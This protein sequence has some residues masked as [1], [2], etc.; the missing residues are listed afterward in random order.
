MWRG[1]GLWFIVQGGAFGACEVFPFLHMAPFA[2]V[3]FCTWHPITILELFFLRKI[4]PELTAAN[5]PLFAEEEWPWANIRAHLPLLYMWDTYHS[6]ACQ[7]VPCPHLGWNWWNP[8]RQSRTCTLNYCATGQAP[9]WT[10]LVSTGSVVWLSNNVLPW[11][12]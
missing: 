10:F 5:P 8:G 3:F 11:F 12:L 2:H 1:R 6:M 4:S 9:S 7:A